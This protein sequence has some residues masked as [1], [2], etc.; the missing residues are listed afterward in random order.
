[1]KYCTGD[2]TLALYSAGDI[3]LALYSADLGCCNCRRTR[4]IVEQGRG[5]GDRKLWQTGGE[6]S[7]RD[8]V[9]FVKG[10]LQI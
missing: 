5:Q 3:T 6:L 4:K 7:I 2:I 10:K 9:K 1:M 8:L